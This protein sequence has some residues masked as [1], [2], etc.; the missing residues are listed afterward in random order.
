MSK[1]LRRVRFILG[2]ALLLCI[3]AAGLRA[4][5]GAGALRGQILDPSG[6]SIPGA[7][8]TATG[9]DGALKVAQTNSEG[10]FVINGLAPG[11]YKVAALAK[12][13]APYENAGVDIAPNKPQTLDIRLAVTMEKQEITVSDTGKVDVSPTSNAGA[14]VLKGEDLEALSDNPDDLAQDLQ[15]LAGPAAG[16]NGGQIYIDGFTGGQLPPKSSIR[17]IRVNSNPF[18][19]EYDRLGFGRIEIFTKPGTDR[20]RGQASFSFGD[21]TFNSRNPFAPNRP[22]YQQ[23]RFEGNLSGPITKKASFFLGLER[24]DVGSASVINATILDA[25][26]N[27]TSFAQAVPNSRMATE[28]N[29]RI[30][31]QLTTNNT[32]VARYGYNPDRRENQGVGQFSLPS[33]ATNRND[34]EHTV[35]IAETAVLGP[36]TITETRF[37]FQRATS[38]Q[39]GDSTQPTIN[40]AEAFTSGGAGV[41]LS[42]NTQNNYEL[43]SVTSMQRSKH[44]VKF[45]ARLHSATLSDSS[46][47]NYNGNFLFTNIIAYQTTLIGRANGLTPAQIRAQGGGPS[48]FTITFGNPLA[49][50]S[51]SDV[52][53]FVQDDWRV[54]QNFSLNLGLRYETQNN[55]S[56]HADVAPRL[57]F[58]WGVGG[59]KGGQPKTVIRGGAG[60]FYDRF[61]ESLTL[62]ALRLNG[63]N[64]RQYKVPSPDFFPNVPT[65]AS[66][67]GNLLSQAIQ[68][69]DP[70]VRA[71]YTI[72]EAVSLE[73][74][75]TKSVMLALTYA[76]SRGVHNLRSRNI[77]APILL[78]PQ[79]PNSRVFPFGSVGNIYSYESTGVFNQNQLIAN[80]NARVGTKFTLFGF[81]MLNSAKSDT[82][83]A[84]T[85]P[86]N[87]YDLSTEYSH[88]AFDVRQRL[89]MGSSIATRWGLR[90]SPFIIASS[91]S[92]FNITVG[93]DLNGDSIF[94]DRPAF[95]TDLT[96]PGVKSLGSVAFDPNP[97]AGQ[98]IIPRNYGIGPGQFS[99]NLRLSKTIGFG[100]RAGAR[101]AV[102]AGGPTGGFRGVGGPRG[103]G[104]RGGGGGPRGGGGGFAG[105]G[106][107]G[108]GGLFGDS[109]PNKRYNLTF[110]V[111]ARNILN[112]VNLGTPIANLSSPKFGQST[113]IVGGFFGPG[114]GGPGG[115]AAANRTVEVQL[116]FSF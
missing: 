103:G 89:F 42:S 105:G 20:F 84:G 60:V 100:E 6:A 76:H 15:A 67:Q 44:A 24:Q 14:L 16:P 68:K 48:Q 17:E 32:L 37:R 29:P 83:G 99:I 7:T 53:P 30:D 93:R 82:D 38:D 62:T 47:A 5:S 115:T 61:S 21:A 54:R 1:L 33:Q 8:V 4:Q 66:L 2:V 74:Q 34:G 87:Q 101:A 49:N 9:A 88:A 27:I 104:E 26:N 98:T 114:G 77:N 91:G 109:N 45:G 3:S 110:S 107:G 116:R 102:E 69:V 64:Q 97:K 95:A 90:W 92:P 40:V 108:P 65:E 59:G 81:Y 18:S 70:N 11:K 78:D 85:F 23:K 71:P 58:A 50:I 111:S 96:A 113:G 25:S 13:F 86:S 51:Q 35:Q 46:N 28:I 72:Q 12:G 80:I 56:D 94:N 43:W 106:H 52:S 41:G 22:P 55:I 57:G 63:I 36:R 112:T 19:A 75:L 39:T 10:K 31:Y 73:R 79:N